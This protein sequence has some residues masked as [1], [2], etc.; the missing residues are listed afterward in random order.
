MPAMTETWRLGSDMKAASRA[1]AD[2]KPRLEHDAAEELSSAVT[3]SATACVSAV[4]GANR[5]AGRRAHSGV[6]TTSYGSARASGGG[7]NGA[8]TTLLKLRRVRPI[9]AYMIMFKNSWK[10][11]HAPGLRI[12]V[13]RIFRTSHLNAAMVGIAGCVAGGAA[14]LAACSRRGV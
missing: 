10:V 2:A 3:P 13:S 9:R 7:E 1:S 6:S 4:C 14:F 12:F 5:S 11:N 8:S